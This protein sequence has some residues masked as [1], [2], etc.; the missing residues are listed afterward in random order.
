[1]SKS[2]LLSKRKSVCMHESTVM[3]EEI[4]PA[5][6][7]GLSTKITKMLGDAKLLHAQKEM[8]KEFTSKYNLMPVFNSTL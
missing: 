2:I 1:M 7:V 8:A 5:S 6:G 4:A 3:S